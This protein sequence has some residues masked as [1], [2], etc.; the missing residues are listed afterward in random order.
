MTQTALPDLYRAYIACLNRQDWPNLHR[1]VA[2]DARHNGRPFGLAGYR[3]ARARFRGDPGPSVR[4][5]AFGLRSAAYREP[6]PLRLPA[7]SSV[8][9]ASGERQAGELRRERY[10][11]LSRRAHCRSLVGGRQG[12]DRSAALRSALPLKSYLFFFSELCA[13]LGACPNTCLF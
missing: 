7:E 10:L 3:D 5:R 2:E 12:G 4:H 9:R 1:F 6:A 11:P 8:S 13:R